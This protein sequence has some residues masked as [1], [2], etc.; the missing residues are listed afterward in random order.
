MEALVRVAITV[1]EEL[2]EEVLDKL[3]ESMNW[4]LQAVINA[5]GWYIKY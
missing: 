2:D 3:V 5:G 1:W 4:R